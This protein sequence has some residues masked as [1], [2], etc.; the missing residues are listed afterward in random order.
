MAGKDGEKLLQIR[1]HQGVQ[2]VRR[3]LDKRS[4]FRNNYETFWD[5][6]G[7]VCTVMLPLAIADYSGLGTTLY[8]LSMSESHGFRADA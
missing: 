3:I 7:Q 1:L 6:E 8:D 4:V 5:C 2:E